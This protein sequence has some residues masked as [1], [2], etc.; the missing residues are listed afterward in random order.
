MA[1]PLGLMAM[2]TGT[3]TAPRLSVIV[4]TKNESHHL[5]RCLGSAAFA[6]EQVVVDHGSTDGTPALARELGARVVETADWP[7]FGIQK[8]RALDAARGDWVLCLDADEWLSDGLAAS[9]REVIAHAPDERQPAGYELTRISAFCGQWMRAGGWYPDRGVRLVRRG[10][11]AFSSDLVHE[12]LSVQGRV[13]RLPGLLLHDSIPSLESAIDK[14][15][16]YSTGRAKDLLARGQRGSLGRALL[17]GLWA[18]V[19]TYVIRRGFIDGRLG[20]VL[21][22]HNAESTY[23]RYLKMWLGDV[24]RRPLPPPPEA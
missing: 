19:R 10:H 24:A 9:I 4:I 7:G 22:V 21:A 17:H 23:Y 2:Q 3:S 11:A 6:S 15:D 1:S 20:F 12:R 13:A 5:R 8:Q 16:R 18:F 14:M